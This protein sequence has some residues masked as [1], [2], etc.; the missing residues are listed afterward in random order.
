MSIRWCH[1]CARAAGLIGQ[2]IPSALTG[3]LYQLG[4]FIKHTLPTGSPK[5]VSIFSEPTYATYEN[6]VVSSLASGSVER[7]DSGRTNVVWYAGSHIGATWQHGQPIFANDTVKVV[8]TGDRLH[9]FSISSAGYS[10]A[11]CSTCGGPI[12]I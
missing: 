5:P 6:F 3:N 12:L 11:T 8:C 4:K 1:S 9:A 2:E 7:D 10:T